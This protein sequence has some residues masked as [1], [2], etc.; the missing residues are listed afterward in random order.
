[1]HA[2]LG[3][4]FLAAFDAVFLLPMTVFLL[5]M[6]TVFLLPLLQSAPEGRGPRFLGNH[7]PH[8]SGEKIQPVHQLQ[9]LPLVIQ[10]MQAAV[11]VCIHLCVLLMTM[12]T[13]QIISRGDLLFPTS[14]YMVFVFVFLAVFCLCV[15]VFLC[16][17]PFYSLGLFL[18]CFISPGAC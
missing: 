8:Q 17:I 15:C 11:C 13:R 3:Q 18:Q 5:P 12:T 6:T 7:L 16:V 1:M 10:G 9:H 14:L 4:S 2:C